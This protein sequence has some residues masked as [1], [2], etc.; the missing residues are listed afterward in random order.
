MREIAEFDVALLREFRAQW[1][2]APISAQKKIERLRAFFRYGVENDW[3][4]DNPARKLKAPQVRQPP[5]LP[6]TREEM[7]GILTACKF[8]T[9]GP[10]NSTQSVYAPWFCCFVTAVCESRTG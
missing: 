10:L 5:T 3:I 6:F 4:P 1:R 8:F 9:G 7:T 2:D